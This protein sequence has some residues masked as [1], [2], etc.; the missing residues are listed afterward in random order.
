MK[1]TVFSGSPKGEL[2]ISL[3]Y[4]K[5]MKKDTKDVEYEI[6]HIGEKISLMEKNK[7]EFD[8]AINSVKNSDGVI[9]VFPVYHFTVPSQLKRFIELANERSLANVFKGKYSTSI[10]TSIHFY[11]TLAEKYIHAVSEDFGMKYTKGFL[12]GM[13]DLKNEKNQKLLTAFGKSFLEN[14]KD[15]KIVPKMYADINNEVPRYTPEIGEEKKKKNSHK[16][17]LVTDNSSKKG[18]LKNM[19]ETFINKCEN[20]IVVVNLDELET[21]GGC[22]GCC[23]CGYDGECV[24]ADKMTEFLRENF[25]SADGVVIASEIKDR[26]LS[27]QIK[28]M[29]DRSFL[30]GHRPVFKGKKM[31]YIISGKISEHSII[32]EEIN[33]RCSIGGTPLIDCVSDEHLSSE[34]LTKHLEQAGKDLC[35]AIEANVQSQENFYSVSGHKIFRDF[36]YQMRYVFTA[37]HKYYKK[38]NYYDFPRTKIGRSIINI[39]VPQ[40][41]KI[42]PIRKEFSNRIKSEMVKP[43]KKIA[44]EYRGGK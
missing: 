16:I 2:S 7:A 39:L 34:E 12:A 15:K 38:T 23:R 31:M 18:N 22:L 1:I 21:K 25:L 32:Q 42:K 17:I 41:L 44:D 5:Y 13:D 30:H 27:Y 35:M 14:I 26:Y 24:Y 9:W 33:A 36:I 29:W 20:E 10:I 3:Q 11:D 43:I 40:L 8:K 28:R 37:D 4:L 19:L 6:F